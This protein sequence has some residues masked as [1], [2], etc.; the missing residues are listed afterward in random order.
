M[1]SR[2]AYARDRRAGFTLVELLVVIA[3][4]GIL[5]ALLLPAVQAAREAA[6][7]TECL[8]NLKQLGLGLHNY[9]D[10][11][12]T[13]PFAW[14][15]D[16]SAGLGPGMNAQCWGTRILPFIEQTAL[17]DQYDNNW[18]AFS[19]F[20]PIADS[21]V[22]V[23]QTPLEVYTCPSAPGSPQDRM[24]DADYTNAGFP[25]Q[26]RAAPSD[27][28]ASTGVLGVFAG[29]AYA[30]YPGG[31]GG[32]REGG[33]LFT[34][35]DLNNPTQM[36]IHSNRFADF[37]DGTSNTILVG[38]RTGGNTLYSGTQAIADT[39][40]VTTYLPVNGGGW[41]DILNGEHWL[42][43]S[44]YDPPP[45]VPIAQGPCGI[46]CTNVRGNGFHAFHPGGCQFLLGDGSV[47]FIS[48]TVS[49]FVLA[50]AITRGKGESFTLP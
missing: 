48:E 43:G 32:D 11:H 30:N 6:R 39:T 49:Q 4:I 20:G 41:G 3:I 9:H 17:A 2:S 8:N 5:I 18:P 23:I 36:D 34:G 26:F 12:K 44:L 7:R 31:A 10:V 1:R 47:R 38:E 46:N 37:T 33:L 25:I 24:Y 21:N 19:G 16:L 35:S 13:F 15:V 27:Y 22:Q 14:M 28:T 45:T 29:I 50:S 40:F 42:G